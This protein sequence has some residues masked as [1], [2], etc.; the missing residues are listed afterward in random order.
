MPLL[1]GKKAIGHN[2]GIMMKEGKPHEQAVAIAL[3]KTEPKKPSK[4]RKTFM[5]SMK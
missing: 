1:P 3:S 2:I 4:A 5:S